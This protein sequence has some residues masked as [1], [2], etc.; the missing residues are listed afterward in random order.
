MARRAP[1]DNV[2][3]DQF[4]MVTAVLASDWCQKTCVFLAPIR[5]QNGGNRLELVWYKDIVPRGS[6]CH[7]LLFFA[8]HFCAR[9]DFLL[10]PVSAPGSPRMWW[11]MIT[12]LVL[13]KTMATLINFVKV[14]LNWSLVLK[15]IKWTCLD[16][17]ISIFYFLSAKVFAKKTPSRHTMIY[18]H[19]KNRK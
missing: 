16:T 7:S 5:S 13:A 18:L 19:Q 17:T 4:Q 6:S 14:F 2:L 1:G 15:M 10:S 3:P 9:L 11:M 8:P 12:M